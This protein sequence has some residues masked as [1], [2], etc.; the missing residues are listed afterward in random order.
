MP[1]AQTIDTDTFRLDAG[2]VE[3]VDPKRLALLIGRGM[4]DQ[5]GQ[6]D[7]LADRLAAVVL[8]RTGPHSIKGPVTAECI[9]NFIAACKRRAAHADSG[10][11]VDA[12]HSNTWCGIAACPGMPK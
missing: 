9:D 5:A 2:G 11:T 4:K 12:P 3:V 1:A 8:L 6:P 10:C 7:P